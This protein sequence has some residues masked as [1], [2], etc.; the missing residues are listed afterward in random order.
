M[1]LIG[2]TIFS[3]QLLDTN[4]L[5]NGLLPPDIIDTDLLDTDVMD[6]L[7]WKNNQISTDNILVVLKISTKI[8]EISQNQAK[9]NTL[10]L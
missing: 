10:K 3:S 7:T 2:F 1:K 6:T 9:K 4:K 8:Q 5:N